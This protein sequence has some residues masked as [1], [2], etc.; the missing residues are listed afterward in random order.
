MGSFIH[1]DLIAEKLEIART[2]GL[3]T[4]YFVSPTGPVRRPDASVKVWCRPDTDEASIRD[5]LVRLLHGL[6]ADDHILMVAP[7]AVA[8]IAGTVADEAPPLDT[9]A[10]PVAA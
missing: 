2:M 9:T 1:H 8:E 5:Q 6:V 3:V 10:V 7:D 4:D